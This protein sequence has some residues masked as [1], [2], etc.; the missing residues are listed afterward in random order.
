M[1]QKGFIPIL[2]TLGVVIILGITGGVYYYKKL[3]FSLPGSSTRACTQEAKQCPDGSFVGRTGPNC[4]FS[5]CLQATPPPKDKAVSAK[6]QSSAALPFIP[7]AN[8]KVNLINEQGQPVDQGSVIIRYKYSSPNEI[9]DMEYPRVVQS[10][11]LL[12]LEPSLASIPMSFEVQGDNPTSSV[13]RSSN[14]DYW[15]AVANSKSDYV[16]EI[17]MTV[18]SSTPTVKIGGSGMYPTYKNGQTY[19]VKNSLDFQRGDV[20]IYRNPK[21]FDDPT[22]YVKRIISLPGESIK[23]QEGKVYI[24]GVVLNEFYLNSGQQTE[25]GNFLK[26]NKEIKVP[27]NNYFV[28]GDNRNASSDSREWGFVAKELILGKIGECYSRCSKEK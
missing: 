22:Y 10:G 9:Y 15:E 11:S 14:A 8:L 21:T 23:I 4:E 24:N 2:I 5:P 28:L 19:L 27:E 20:V 17:T 6:G 12:H 25:G 3:Y 7:G 16:A 18:N 1:N 26:E 13:Y